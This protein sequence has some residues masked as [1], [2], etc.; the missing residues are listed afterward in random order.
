VNKDF[1]Q[2]VTGNPD[3]RRFQVVSSAARRRDSRNASSEYHTI[4]D[5][6]DVI[7]AS[8][9]LERFHHTYDALDSPRISEID[10]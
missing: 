1:Q 7:V 9:A 4:V 5:M 6:Y 2:A 10:F 3:I 8:E